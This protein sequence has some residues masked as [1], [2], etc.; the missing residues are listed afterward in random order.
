MAKDV[1]DTPPMG[2]SRRGKKGWLKVDKTPQA[3]MA[4]KVK[5]ENIE[6]KE[7]L[8]QL[9]EL[10]TGLIPTKKGKK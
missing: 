2:M 1:F 7:R 10:V 8:T 4:N 9:E 5:Q 6:L 3:I